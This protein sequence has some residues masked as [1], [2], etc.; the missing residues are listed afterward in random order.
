M[1]STAD[2]IAYRHKLQQFLPFLNR[3]L[4]KLSDKNDIAEGKK[5]KDLID[6]ISSD[7][8]LRQ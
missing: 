8:K 4:A 7:V 1:S 5:V 2:P 6:Y 3:T